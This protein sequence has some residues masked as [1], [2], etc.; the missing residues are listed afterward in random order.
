[1]HR[2]EDIEESVRFIKARITI[3][4]E[5]G[6]VLGTG[7]SGFAEELTEKQEIP[8]RAIPHFV[9]STV[10]G[11]A[12]K[13]VFGYLGQIP[14]VMMAGR[15]HYYEGYSLSEVTFPIR[16][17]KYLGVQRMIIT[18]V[19]GSLNEAL[20]AGDI[21]LIHDHINLLPS[22]P[23]RGPNDERIGP[24]F[25]DMTHTYDQTLLQK[26]LAVATA[27]GI[28]AQT[29]VYVAVPGPS[30]E[31][32]SERCYLQKIGADAVGMSTV[33]EVIVCRH[34]GLAVNVFSVI[35]NEFNVE[36]SIEEVIS[37]AR[38]AESNLRA[39]IKGILL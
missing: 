34:M 33:P 28:R 22:N 24:R 20:R 35:S 31:T 38:S 32:K 37:V 18:N 14:M 16:V 9:E 29:G 6:I 26:G 23:L 25:P 39:L 5:V 19:S 36:T 10:K 17:L 27:L 13:L 3:S 8:Y 2:L 21:L 15:F 7:L 12:G 1:M 4:P 30:L 11:H